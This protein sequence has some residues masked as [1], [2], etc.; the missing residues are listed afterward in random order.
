M[1][2]P[3]WLLEYIEKVSTF[4]NCVILDGGSHDTASSFNTK[5]QGGN[6]EKEEI[7]CFLGYVLKNNYSLDCSTVC[8]S[9][10]R[11]VGLL[12]IEEVR[13]EFDNMRDMCRSTNEDN[14]VHAGLVNFRVSEDSQQARGY[15]RR[16]PGKGSQ[17]EH[18]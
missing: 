5:G 7:L 18:G 6:I 13:H 14:F 10:V 2:I 16:G 1:S 17:N 11:I 12:A 8:D 15:C 4:T 3:D 9:L